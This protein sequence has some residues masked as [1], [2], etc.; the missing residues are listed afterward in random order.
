[1]HF[2][3]EFLDLISLLYNKE[4][5]GMVPNGKSL[6]LSHSLMLNFSSWNEAILKFQLL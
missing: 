3:Y 1:M 5:K 2:K 6:I 4:T